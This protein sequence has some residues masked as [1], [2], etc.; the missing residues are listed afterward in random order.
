MRRLAFFL[1]LGV[2]ALSRASS[3]E[4][5]KLRA[6]NGIVQ[7]VGAAALRDV[8]KPRVMEIQGKVVGTC[9]SEDATLVIFQ[10]LDG[11]T[12]EVEAKAMPD[13]LAEN[14]GSVRLLVRCVRPERGAALRSVLLAA[15]PELDVVQVEEAYWRAQAAK[16]KPT[17]AAKPKP[18]AATNPL[19]S[20]GT[21]IVGRIGGPSVIRRTWVVPANEATPRYAAF[22]RNQNP[23]LTDAQATRIAQGVVG[24]SLQYGVDARLVMAMLMVESGF[25]PNSVSRSGAV[26]LGQLMPGTAQWMGVRNSYD[27]M[28]NLY[29]TVKL[30]RTHLDQYRTA[31]GADVVR[32]LAAYNAGMGAVKRYNGVPPFR[33][34]QN[35]VRR[36]MEI[37]ARICG[38]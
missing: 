8:V 30:L 15:A 33:E 6:Q 26:G 2:A 38:R 13:W 3:P 21:T 32:S 23:R 34:T 27:T 9:R 1:A 31:A 17:V 28:D 22:I 37:Y 5:L 4:Y 12:Q 18:R 36:V 19:A 16:R 29:G 11:D 24:F 35:Y 10:R 25:D 14:E 7:A 20:R